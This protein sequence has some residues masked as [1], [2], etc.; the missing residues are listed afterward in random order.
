V[1]SSPKTF[2]QRGTHAAHVRSA[3]MILHAHECRA[4]A[5]E[6]RQLA[7][8]VKRVSTKTALEQAAEYWSA[9]AERL[10]QRK[11]PGKTALHLP[12]P[13]EAQTDSVPV[14]RYLVSVGTAL[15]LGLL[16]LSAQFE[17][18][19]PDAAAVSKPQT[20]ASLLSAKP[21]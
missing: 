18:R 14:F 11:D 3:D 17:S 9:L 15:F 5:N 6:A 4:R 20:N 10:E 21:Y 13:A 1:R 19:V 8:Q 7:W 12:L 16:A 2:L